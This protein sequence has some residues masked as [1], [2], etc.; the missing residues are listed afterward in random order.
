MAKYLIQILVYIKNRRYFM[1]LPYT[2]DSMK[3]DWMSLEQNQ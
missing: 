1:Y 3:Y 2:Y